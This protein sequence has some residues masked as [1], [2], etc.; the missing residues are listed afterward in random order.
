MAPRLIGTAEPVTAERAELGEGPRWDAERGRLLWV[1][2]DGRALH[3]GDRR[4]CFDSTVGAAA[5]T[6]GDAVLVALADRLVKVEPESGT[7]EPL[8]RIP[9]PR[10][11]MRTN[12]GACDAAGRFWIG[13]MAIDLEPGAGSLY[14][15]DPDGTLSEMLPAVTLSNG[16]GWSPDE[17]SMYFV[18]SEEQRVDVLDFDA[19]AGTVANRRP[20]AH[21]AKADGTPDGL[22]VDDEGGIWVALWGGRQVRRYTPDGTLDARIDVPADNVTA[23]C[24]AGR[25]MFI[26]TAKPDG[27]LF[28]IDPG[29]SGPPAEPFGG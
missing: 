1:D 25:T 8:I 4:L 29:V 2:I 23:C 13:T 20:L 28:T 6:R 19:A 14:R 10:A 27:R 16:L 24:F 21:V 11:G 26:T 15:Y 17:R 12:D 3:V 7:I 18:D 9:H 5:P 22:A